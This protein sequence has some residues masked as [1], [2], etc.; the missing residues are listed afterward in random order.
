M[1]I[2]VKE[3]RHEYTLAFKKNN[4]DLTIEQWPILAILYDQNTL[5]QVQIAEHI[6]RFPQSLSATLKLLEKNR[7][8]ERK[9]SKVDKRSHEICLTKKGCEIVESAYP[10]VKKI[11]EKQWKN[12]TKEDY[13]K[14]YSILEQ[15]RINIR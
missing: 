14:F 4:I 1:N 2:A 5:S 11:R 3:I 6:M 8:I 10:H 13:D 15:I 7:C 9:I 12:L